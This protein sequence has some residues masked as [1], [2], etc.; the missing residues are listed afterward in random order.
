[1]IDHHC[2]D[3]NEY[4]GGVYPISSKETNLE[5]THGKLLPWQCQSC[6]AIAK[7]P[8]QENQNEK[9][10]RNCCVMNHGRSILFRVFPWHWFWILL[11]N[12][13]ICTIMDSDLCLTKI[14][15]WWSPCSWWFRLASA[16]IPGA[17]RSRCVFHFLSVWRIVID[18]YSP[19]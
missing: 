19:L 13:F 10:K 15:R 18:W 8:C 16:L 5:K 9:L 11:S 1:M 12:C 2:S 4:V 7:V 14:A 17:K 3:W 6:P